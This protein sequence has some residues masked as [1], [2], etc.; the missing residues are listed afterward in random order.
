M[1]TTVCL[2]GP[3]APGFEEAGHV[4]EET[5]AEEE[6]RYS[7]FRPTSELSRVNVHSGSWTPIT[8]A[9]A[10]LLD[11]AIDRARNT[12]GSFDPTVLRAME[13]AGYDRDLDEVIAAPG[14]AWRPAAPCGHWP[15]IERRPGAVR[16]PPGVGLDLGGVAKGWTVDIAAE[17]ALGAGLPWVL[18]SA[19]GDLRVVGE[20]PELEIPIDDPDEAGRSLGALRLRSGAVAT[21]SIRRRSWGPGL[22]HVIDPRTGAP[23]ATGVAQATVWAPTCADAEIASTVALL[24]GIDGAARRPSLLVSEDGTLYRSFAGA[25]PDGRVAA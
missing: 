14:T 12:A 22:H 11:F 17:R 21:S 13:A 8:D 2:F 3:D 19:G 23:A 15:A 6:D 1:G 5:F 10:A 16:L 18:V 24:D 25:S 4:V 20:A 7:R 9:F